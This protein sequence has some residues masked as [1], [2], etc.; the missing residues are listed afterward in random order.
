M[1]VLILL[2][3]ALSVF[4]NIW[5]L[6]GG[7]NWG[8]DFAQYII[9][10]RNIIE[11]KPYQSGV[12][13]ENFVTYPPGLPLLI[14]PELKVLGLDFKAFK[15]FNI[16]F[17]YL[18]V[19]FIYRLFL[20]L[21]GQ[22]FALLAALFLS[23]SSFFFTYKQNVLS[24]IPFF[25][26]VCV[27]LCMFGEGES[28]CLIWLLSMSGALW[29]RSA[30]SILFA[31]ALFYFI[32]IK[33]DK[34]M[35][36]IVL[37]VFLLNEAILFFWMGWHPGVLVG[38]WQDPGQMLSS[39]LYNFP[40]AF[41][42]FWYF[43][44]PYQTVVSQALFKILDPV[45]T[46]VSPVL[47]IIILWSFVRGLRKRSLSFL[48]CFSFI[49]ITLLILWSGNTSPPDAFTRFIFPVLPFAF[50][51]ALRLFK[52]ADGYHLRLHGL[53]RVF[54]LILLLINLSNVVINWDFN[55]DMLDL[56][57]NKGLVNWVEQNTKPDEHFMFWKP[58]A[59]ALLT[60]R[61]G[62]APWIFPSQEQ[63]FMQRVR[64]L[65]ISYVLSLKD[66]DGLNAKLE[67]SGQFKLVWENG[68][69]L[70]FKPIN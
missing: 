21:E 66:D 39:I 54:L 10:A 22:R 23:L 34:R 69:Y 37:S 27:S 26:F 30:G 44:C 45:V 28:N 17:W 47:Y 9:N 41:H 33:R 51:G 24:D 6:N 57:A 7:H 52:F 68:A 8:D 13:L 40:T 20:R 4:F 35:S 19:Y 16:I 60:R 2:L 67:N 59:L 62:T 3:I 58:R 32:F 15:L 29:F 18:S 70:V 50:W 53:A 1:K 65:K 48:E 25:F 36:A 56:P 43:L 14:A 31:A 38:N 12:I 11:G 5:T 61:E 64:D 49:Y 46:V 42:A 55:D 63:G